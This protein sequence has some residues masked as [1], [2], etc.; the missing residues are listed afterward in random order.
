MTLASVRDELRKDHD[1]SGG[2]FDD[3]E[4]GFQDGVK[5]TLAK[6]EADPQF[7]LPEQVEA[8]AKE[9]EAGRFFNGNYT[10]KEAARRLRDIAGA[11]P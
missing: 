1:P 3:Y 8:L 5:E 6:L 9:G 10:T 7:R 11:G 2:A 4:K